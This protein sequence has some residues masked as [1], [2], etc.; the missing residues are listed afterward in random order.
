MIKCVQI[1]RQFDE[2]YAL[3]AQTNWYLLMKSVIIAYRLNSWL[4]LNISLST[5]PIQ[6]FKT[7]YKERRMRIKRNRNSSRID[8]LIPSGSFIHCQSTK[9]KASLFSLRLQQTLPLFFPLLQV[10]QQHKISPCEESHSI[11]HAM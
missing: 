4:R 8:L 10:I 5:Q 2:I 7:L 11:H 6:K 9:C 3:L 1:W